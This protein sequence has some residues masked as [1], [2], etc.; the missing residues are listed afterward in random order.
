MTTDKASSRGQS[1]P[2]IDESHVG[3]HLHDMVVMLAAG[4]ADPRRAAEVAKHNTALF[5]AMNGSVDLLGEQDALCAFEAVAVLL[6]HMVG[7][8]PERAARGMLVYVGQRAAYHAGYS[9]GAGSAAPF[10]VSQDDIG[11]GGHA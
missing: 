9:R 6:G 10:K 1:A 8:M 11:Q 2:D 7:N 4:L 3:E 5:A